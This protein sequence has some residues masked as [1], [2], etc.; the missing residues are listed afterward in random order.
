MSLDR[1]SKGEILST[2]ILALPHENTA[3]VQANIE[4]TS[5]NLS[6]LSSLR[7]SSSRIRTIR[8]ERER[9]AGGGRS[10]RLI[11]GR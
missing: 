2:P 3:R 1:S 4:V 8:R 11:R 5:D 7:S 9:V 6:L 10:A